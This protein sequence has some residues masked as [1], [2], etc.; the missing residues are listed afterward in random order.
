[1]EQ[2]NNK[3]NTITTKMDEHRILIERFRSETKVAIDIINEK[4]LILL[5]KEASNNVQTAYFELQPDLYPLSSHEQLAEM[6]HKILT[7]P[8][9]KINLVSPLSIHMS[10]CEYFGYLFRRYSLSLVVSA[11]SIFVSDS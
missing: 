2:L 9:F 6:E 4:L 7:E 5:E 8:S 1:M 10:Y 3:M 11:L